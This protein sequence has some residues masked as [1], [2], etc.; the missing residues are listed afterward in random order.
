MTLTGEV[1]SNKI[2][3]ILIHLPSHIVWY[4]LVLMLPSIK[5]R[6]GPYPYTVLLMLL[7][8]RELCEDRE[9]A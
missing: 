3:G 6:R 4:M 8:T 7:P 1:P 9:H 5:S 2:V